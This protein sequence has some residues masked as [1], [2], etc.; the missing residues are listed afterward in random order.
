MLSVIAEL[1]CSE[2]A[3]IAE[4][5]ANG[6]QAHLVD[7]DDDGEDEVACFCPNCATREFDGYHKRKND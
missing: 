4:E 5:D 2:C 7:L 6:W 1:V 3:R